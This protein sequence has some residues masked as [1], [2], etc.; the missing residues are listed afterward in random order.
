MSIKDDIYSDYKCGQNVMAQKWR[1]KN[2]SN[3]SYCPGRIEHIKTNSYYSI[4]FSD[5][6]KQILNK[7]FFYAE[8]KNNITELQN[9]KSKKE[10]QYKIGRKVIVRFV[11]G[12]TDIF[13]YNGTIIKQDY[14]NNEYVIEPD[15]PLSEN[16]KKYGEFLSLNR[17]IRESIFKREDIYTACDNFSIPIENTVKSEPII[18][19][20]NIDVSNSEI[21]NEETVEED[22][23]TEEKEN[24]ICEEP[25]TFSSYAYM[26]KNKLTFGIVLLLLSI[27]IILI[28]LYKMF[29]YIEDIN[30]IVQFLNGIIGI[31]V[32]FLFFKL[33]KL[34]YI[35]VIIIFFIADVYFKQSEPSYIYQLFQDKSMNQEDISIKI[36]WLFLYSL[37]LGP[38]F[39]LFHFL[40]FLPKK[41][42]YF[43]HCEQYLPNFLDY[44][45]GLV[46]NILNNNMPF[47]IVTLFFFLFLYILCITFFFDGNT[48]IREKNKTGI[49]IIKK[50]NLFNKK[51]NLFSKKTENKNQSSST[52]TTTTV[53]EEE[54]F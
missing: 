1:M 37:S 36:G 44:T 14:D 40:L 49:L 51:P 2:S 17:I 4:I 5:G 48:D 24:K 22:I 26:L 25:I 7:D 46:P 9:Y 18:N 39:L 31:V 21:E 35:I 3:L 27:T 42:L 11:S 23:K 54:V 43:I 32:T 10:E 33:I 41:I 45:Y 19:V 28:I 15:K 16:S 47:Y 20:G 12:S 53:E 29:L 38:I 52:I 6:T 34:K 50:P 30:L 8:N 13:Y